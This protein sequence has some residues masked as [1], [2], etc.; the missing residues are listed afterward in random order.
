MFFLLRMFQNYPEYVEKVTYLAY[1]HEKTDP[2]LLRKEP[3][4]FKRIK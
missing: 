2:L 1:D 4:I 3:S